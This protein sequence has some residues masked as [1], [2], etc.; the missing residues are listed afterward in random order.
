MKN[1]VEA[2]RGFPA[3]LTLSRAWQESLEDPAA[4]K[5]AVARNLRHYRELRG[6]SHKALAQ[7]STVNLAAIREIE[8]GRSLPNIPTLARLAD[9]LAMSCGALVECSVSPAAAAPSPRKTPA[10]ALARE[11]RAALA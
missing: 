9:A 7:A 4:V 5:A 11:G 6:L 8:A 3:F 1:H 2:E 10:S